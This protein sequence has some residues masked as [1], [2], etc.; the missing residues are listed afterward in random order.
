MR[1]HATTSRI[2][3]SIFPAARTNPIPLQHVTRFHNRPRWCGSESVAA[4]G[5]FGPRCSLRASKGFS[6]AA[7]ATATLPPLSTPSGAKNVTLHITLDWG[8]QDKDKKKEEDQQ[9]NNIAQQPPPSTSTAESDSSVMESSM[10]RDILLDTVVRVLCKHAEPHH[11][12]PWSSYYTSSSSSGVIIPGKRVLTNAHSVQQQTRVKL[13][14]GGSEKEYQATV[15][16]V[17]TECDCALLT[18]EDDEFWEGVT[19]LEFEN[20]PKLLESVTVVGYPGG[21]DVPSVTSGV[22]KCLNGIMYYHSCTMLP[23]IQI[24]AVTTPGNSGGPVFNSQWK[25]IGLAFQGYRFQ[26]ISEVIPTKVIQRFIRDYE[27]NGFPTLGIRWQEMKHENLRK[28]MGM[29]PGRSGIFINE[30]E[31]TS[32]ESREVFKKSDILLSF[33]GVKIDNDGKVPCAQ[34]GGRVDYNYILFEKFN[35]ET[36]RVEILR[37]SKIIER[38]VKLA[39]HKREILANIKTKPISYYIIGGFVFT[40]L[41]EKYLEDKFNYDYEGETPMRML[42]KFS[43]MLKSPEKEIVILSR[44]VSADINDAYDED[45]FEDMEVISLNGVE[46]KNLKNLASMVEN[47]EDEFLQFDLEDGK[48]I[49]VDTKK[50][51]SS[52]PKIMKKHSIHSAMS[53]DLLKEIKKKPDTT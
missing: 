7:T 49:V 40:S 16:A 39:N 37:D 4:A 22:V 12:M 42:E 14:R 9:P 45:D 30:I 13:K 31:P 41:S 10:Q 18:V 51:K 24:D 20:S 48:R 23:G 43:G 32:P 50:A 34:D 27:K 15:L 1:L 33:D 3:F 26:S 46:I 35:G 19:P 53:D 44:V 28:S 38:D 8:D 29:P 2:L 11:N 6:S 17:G 25:C 5:V 21:Q 52:N 36:A 47:C